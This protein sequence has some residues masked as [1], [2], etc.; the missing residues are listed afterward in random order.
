METLIQQLVYFLRFNFIVV[1][2]V[3]G[4][5]VLLQHITMFCQMNYRRMKLLRLLQK[6][7]GNPGLSDKLFSI[8]RYLLLC[9]SMFL[10]GIWDYPCEPVPEETFTYPPSWSLYNLYQLL[11]STVIDS[12]FP[13]Q[14]TCLANLFCTAPFHILWSTSRSGALHLIFHTCLHPISVFFSQHMFI[15]SQPVLL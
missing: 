6:L 7:K 11:P 8:F 10:C 15:P 13:V 2:L 14:I 3:A 1:A 5:S 4:V 12:I 9:V